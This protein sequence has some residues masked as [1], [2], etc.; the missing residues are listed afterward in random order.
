VKVVLELMDMGSLKDIA[1][2]ARL[3][4]EW[5]MGKLLIPEAVMSKMMQ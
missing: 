3:N 2:L 5:K 4:P 1:K